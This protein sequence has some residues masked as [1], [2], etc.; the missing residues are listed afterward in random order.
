MLLDRLK[1]E[2]RA[3]HD[4]IEADLDLLRPNLSLADYVGLLQ[5]YH[6]FFRRWEP[7]VGALVGDEAFFGPRRKLG[8]LADDLD[9]RGAKP[10]T[11]TAPVPA[12]A[13]RAEAMGSLYVLEGSTM[14]GLV[15]ARHI[16]GVL[17]LRGPGARYF[18]NY[19]RDAA[20]RWRTFRAALADISRPEDEDA[21][22]AAAR[23]TFV[24][25]NRWLCPQ[26]PA[27]G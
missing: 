22:V 9:Q 3:D 17:G 20:E 11:L 23:G 10:S 25:L 2:T 14:G 12:L 13:S 24:L 15:I 7:R 6:A 21:I 5:R 16:E 27:H 8:L 26:E 18:S 1:R 19:G 4:R